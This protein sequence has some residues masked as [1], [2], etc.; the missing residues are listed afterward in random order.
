MSVP[1]YDVIVIGSGPGGLTAAVALAQA[2]KKVLV[3]EQHDVPGGWT[4]SFTI[5]GYRF[6]PGV[7]YIGELQEGGHLE[8][9]YRGLGVSEDLVF[10]E[11]NPQG[12]DHIYVGEQ[13]FDL[14]AGRAELTERL[15]QY[16]PAEAYGIRQYLNAVS[17]LMNGVSS[18]NRIRGPLSAIRQIPNFLH[19]LKWMKRSGQDLVD[20]YI[21]DPVLKAV[22]SGQAGDHGLPPDQVS[23]FVHAG[24][25]QHY[26]N[27]GFYPKGGAASIPRAFT[28]ALKRH[29]GEL[30]LGIAV[31]QILVEDGQA[32]GVVLA[33]DERLSASI[34]I[35]NADPEV[36]FKQLVGS[37]YLSQRLKK[38]LK[39]VS[40]STSALSLFFAADMD[41][42]AAGLDSGNNWYYDH[43]DLNQLYGYGQTDH[44]MNADSAAAV[45]LTVTTL[46]DPTKHYG[47]RHS[48]EAFT[49]VNYAPFE[50]WSKV[51]NRDDDAE[52]QDLKKRLAEK[53]FASLERRIPGLRE[54]VVYWNLSTPLTNVHYINATRGN[55][56]G[57]NKNA[58]QVGPGS[59]PVKTELKNLYMVGASTVSHG[60]S[61]ATVSGLAA[62][63]S[64]LKRGARGILVQN[65]PPL[66]IRQAEPQ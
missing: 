13:K 63:K 53:M 11:L 56:Y 39:N 55:L 60:V 17:S 33:N 59:F 38:K 27:G 37:Q 16:F 30:R 66:E 23:V 6:S 45:F 50:K 26:F 49:F 47:G 40:Y 28:R 34:V 44:I 42:R 1:K 35:S 51:E 25:T 65:G 4:H 22:L 36:T 19:V 5:G 18:L 12:F 8:R 20:Q 31:K 61:G 7:H 10:Y 41:L 62:A 14:P 57:I 64:I 15:I 52:Y 43:A 3:V 24:I 48:C 46:K 29:G 54:K 32:V 21:G 2:G 58:A 9:I